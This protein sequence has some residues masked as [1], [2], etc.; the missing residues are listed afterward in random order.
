[1]ASEALVASSAHEH[2]PPTAAQIAKHQRRARKRLLKAHRKGERGL[3]N[4]AQHAGKSKRQ[5][6]RYLKAHGLSASADPVDAALSGVEPFDNDTAERL[7]ND[8]HSMGASRSSCW[9]TQQRHTTCEH[10]AGAIETAF[11]K[12]LMQEHQHL[13][14]PVL[15]FD[16]LPVE[17][18]VTLDGGVGA[19]L[20][21]R[22]ALGGG[23]GGP[24]VDLLVVHQRI[25]G[26]DYY[27]DATTD[28]TAY[29]FSIPRQPD[30]SFMFR[31]GVDPD[32]DSVTVGVVLAPSLED[33][34]EAVLGVVLEVSP[35]AD[36]EDSEDGLWLDYW[37]FAN[38]AQ[39]EVESVKSSDRF[40]VVEESWE[41]CTWDSAGQV[42]GI[43]WGML[44]EE[45]GQMVPLTKHQKRGYMSVH[46]FHPSDFDKALPA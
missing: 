28:L 3:A 42:T 16:P 26:V 17:D 27:P 11:G 2:P 12:P 7:L 34:A 33:A 19:S 25:D 37:R 5:A 38:E 45:E 30:S 14:A 9:S 10:L 43:E 6:S 1:M 36:N 22:M 21:G 35:N 29:S 8:L 24:G 41:P 31:T 40:N 4:L 13:D 15:K 18:G 44:V 39:E 46:P 32:D 20:V 23:T